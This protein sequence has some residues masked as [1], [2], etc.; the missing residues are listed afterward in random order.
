MRRYVRGRRKARVEWRS[1][2]LVGFIGGLLVR[3]L[4][5]GIC[6]L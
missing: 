6:N 4:E 2:A 3:R 1:A 5:R